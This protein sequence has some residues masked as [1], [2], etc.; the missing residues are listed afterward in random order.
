MA[1]DPLGP[2]RPR[3]SNEGDLDEVTAVVCPGAKHG[4]LVQITQSDPSING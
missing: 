4:S 3:A 2:S 1:V